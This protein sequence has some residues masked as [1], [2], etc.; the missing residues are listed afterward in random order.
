M[1]PKVWE[2]PRL[3]NAGHIKYF[4]SEM[5]FLF[6]KILVQKFLSK[7]SFYFYFPKGSQDQF[8]LIY[9]SAFGQNWQIEPVVMVK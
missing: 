8:C 1:F 9:Q 3:R 7:N 2:L 6:L 5:F 4:S